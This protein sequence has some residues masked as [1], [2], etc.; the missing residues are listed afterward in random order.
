MLTSKQGIEIF[1][2]IIS[3]SR[4]EWSAVVGFWIADQTDG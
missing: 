3:F 1:I 2:L 4:V